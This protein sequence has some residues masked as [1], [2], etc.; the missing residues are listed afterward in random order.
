MAH[1]RVD[2]SDKVEALKR[3]SRFAKATEPVQNE[4]GPAGPPSTKR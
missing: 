2:R 3:L 1:A 4:G